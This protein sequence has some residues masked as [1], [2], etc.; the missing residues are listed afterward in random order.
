MFCFPLATAK[1]EHYSDVIMGVMAFQITGVSIV[2]STFYSGTNQRKHKS[3]TG[4]CGGNSPVTGEFAS[5]KASNAGN[6][7]IR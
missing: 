1:S 7:S 6:V 2:Y 5:Q 3:F 4:F